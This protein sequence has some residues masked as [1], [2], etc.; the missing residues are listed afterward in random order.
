MC[1]AQLYLAPHMMNFQIGLPWIAAGLLVLGMPLRSQAQSPNSAAA[2]LESVPPFSTVIAAAESRQ[3]PLSGFDIRLQGRPLD[4]GDSFTGLITLKQK[5]SKPTQWLVHLEAREDAVSAAAIKKGPLTLHTSTGR[6]LEFASTHTPVSLRTIGPFMEPGATRKP[7]KLTDERAH[8]TLDEGY[9][10]L[11]L[12]RAAAVLLR[13]GETNEKDAFVF[14]T[15]PFS[16]AEIRKG[17]E[18]ANRLNITAEEERAVAGSVPALLS[19]VDVVRHTEGL[20]DIIYRIMDRPSLWSVVRQVGVKANLAFR[21]QEIARAN[22][23]DWNLPLD[24]NVYQLPLVL[25]INKKPALNLV[26]VV[27]EPDSPL[28]ACGGV[29]GMLAEKPSDDQTY[30]TF[31]I[32]S[33][34]RATTPGQT[35]SAAATATKFPQP[36]S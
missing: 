5:G 10:G 17:C 29:V 1:F 33:A 28:L 16:D 35:E 9:L 32:L 7:P 22:P 6:E 23:A 31:R 2:K 27:T 19:Y 3:I 8:F 18:A 34:Q 15:K 13:L 30:L 12:D 36:G 14:K 11:G 20:S 24:R 25:E 26:L 4:A 21:P